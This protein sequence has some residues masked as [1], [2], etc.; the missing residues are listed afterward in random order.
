MKRG[1]NYE[2]VLDRIKEIEKVQAKKKNTFKATTG[3]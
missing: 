3:V 1:L 2:E